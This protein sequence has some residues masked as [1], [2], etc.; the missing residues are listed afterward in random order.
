MTRIDLPG[1]EF[2]PWAENLEACQTVQDMSREKNF[3]KAFFEGAKKF[4]EVASSTETNNVEGPAPVKEF[5][6]PSSRNK[7]AT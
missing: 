7:N 4:F 1:G 5:Q 6:R 3:L 2:S